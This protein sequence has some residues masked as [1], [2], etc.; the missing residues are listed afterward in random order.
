MKAIPGERPP[1][2]VVHVVFPDLDDALVEAVRS[3]DRDVIPGRPA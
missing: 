3:S 1:E 2:A